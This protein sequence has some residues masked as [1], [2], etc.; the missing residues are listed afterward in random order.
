MRRLRHGLAAAG[1]VAF[2]SFLWAAPA[3]A[4]APD[5]NASPDSSVG[6]V[7]TINN[8]LVTLLTGLV[9]PVIIGFLNNPGN[10]AW[11]KLGLAGAV[12]VAANAFVQTIQADGTA[13]LSQ[14]WILQTIVVFGTAIFSY[15]GVWDPLFR[16]RGGI[17]AATGRG[18]ID[19]S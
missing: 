19:V 17:N 14:E 9:L 18:V 12:S 6:T 1:L 10:P 5:G 8:S 2:L 3:L 11:V 4:Q 13:V 15:L 16:A 7:F